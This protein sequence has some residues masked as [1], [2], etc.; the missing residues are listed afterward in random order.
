MFKSI[1]EEPVNNPK[2]ETKKKKFP[3]EWW[4]DE[5]CDGDDGWNKE[6]DDFDWNSPREDNDDD[7]EDRIKILL[8][9]F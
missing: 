7:W 1:E 4:E 2:E 8:Y 3:T 5:D 9:I 6:W